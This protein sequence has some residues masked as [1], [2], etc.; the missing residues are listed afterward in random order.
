MNVQTSEL[1][2]DATLAALLAMASREGTAQALVR[3]DAAVTRWP[4]DPRLIFLRGSM[5]AQA[6]RY[7]E[8]LNDMKAA[9]AFDPNFLIARFQLG[10]LQLTSQHVADALATWQ[11]LLQLPAEHSLRLFSEGM[12]ALV[13]DRFDDCVRALQAGIQHNTGFVALNRDMQLVV[14][15]VREQQGKQPAEGDAGDHLLL[16]EYAAGQRKH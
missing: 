15:R 16:A 2:D 12:G 3:I 6:E 8:A 11:P 13:E 7:D 10:L 5:R 14:D 4:R 9:I 1:C